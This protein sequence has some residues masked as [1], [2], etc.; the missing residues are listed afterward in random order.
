MDIQTR[1]LKLG[2]FRFSWFALG[3]LLILLFGALLRSKGLHSP[4]LDHPGWRQGDTA[5][6][7][8]NF[9]A[10]KYNILYPQTNYDGP[11]PNYVELE[12]QIVPFLAATLYKIF[13]VHEIFG[14]LISIGFSLGTV[15]LLAFFGRWLFASP[16]AGLA[17]AFFFA[18]FPGSV[19][20]GRTFTPDATMVFFMTAAVYAT[21]RYLLEDATLERRGLAR[22]SALLALAYLAK[23]VSLVALAPVGFSVL[24]R[25]RSGRTMRWSA[26]AVLIVIP[27]VILALYGRA[28]NA[29][30][31]WHWASGIVTLHVIP[32]L[33]A[34]FASWHGFILKGQAFGAVLV[35]LT[36][37]MIAGWWPW[38]I[39]AILILPRSARAPWLVTSWLAAGL[40]YVYVVVTV[41]RVDYYMFLLLPP[42]AL[43]MG[44]ALARVAG[45]LTRTS[46]LMRSA[47]ALA[48]VVAFGSAFVTGQRAVAPYYLYSKNAYRRAVALDHELPKH[49][50]VVMGH[51][52]PDI[53]YY[54]DRY[55][56]EEDPYLWTPFDEESAI[57]KGARYFI[58]IE[59]QRFRRNLELCAW[60]QRFPLLDPKAAWPVY[61]TNDALIKPGTRS[62]WRAFRRA[63]RAGQGR[64]FLNARGVCRLR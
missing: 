49:A 12:L 17:T 24:D 44:G 53:L 22:C 1:E 43:A 9:A 42:L 48:A 58:A 39:I 38:A 31:E 7:A 37:T 19:Y 30:A 33:I 2:A 27:L 64:Q 25:A 16:L 18:V 36:R 46:G 3:L 56:W 28:V 54:I 63:E 62:F 5:S 21:A 14:R 32:G 11:P 13:G 52:G 4:L 61:I 60:M 15:G 6:I 20:Y 10:L 47:A 50:L 59:D 23:P 8:R 41:E 26:I 45:L 40:A 35:L 51:Y 29:H 34:A 57:R 55:G